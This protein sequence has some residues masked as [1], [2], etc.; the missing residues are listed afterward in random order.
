MPTAPR[1]HL[2]PLRV[3]LEVQLDQVAEIDD[4]Q[5]SLTA[6]RQETLKQLWMMIAEGQRLARLLRSA[7][8]QHYNHRAEQIAG[9]GVQPI[10]GKTRKA[11]PTPKSSTPL[12]TVPARPQP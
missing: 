3:Q 6:S 5:T 4:Q 9:F 1:S 2:E 10:R 7:I 8:R 12:L 11:K